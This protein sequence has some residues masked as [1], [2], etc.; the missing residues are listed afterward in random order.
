MKKIGIWKYALILFACLFVISLIKGL[1]VNGVSSYGFFADVAKTA[2]STVLDLILAMIISYI[3]EGVI[4]KRTDKTTIV[5]LTATIIIM[6][7]IGCI[8]SYIH[9]GSIF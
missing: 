1:C 3:I 2:V 9:H 7:I 6:Q 8:V 5:N 4:E